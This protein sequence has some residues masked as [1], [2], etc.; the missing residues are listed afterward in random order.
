MTT[1]VFDVPAAG[2]T[3]WLVFVLLMPLALV[4]VLAAVFWPRPLQVEVTPDAVTIRGSIY[5]RSVPRSE[6]KLDRARVVDLEREPGLK[7]RLRTNGVGLPNYRVGWFRLR[8]RE[9][10][11]CFLTATDR[12]VYLPTKQDYALLLSAENPAALLD[13][14]RN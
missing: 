12:V 1:Q 7:P 8:D 5:G 9:R 6:L 13:A 11:L 4:V 2:G 14:L 10:A 3:G